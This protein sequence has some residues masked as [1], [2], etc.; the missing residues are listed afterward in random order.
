MCERGERNDPVRHGDDTET[1]DE[2]DH[3]QHTHYPTLKLPSQRHR[4]ETC[5]FRNLSQLQKQ[6]K[7]VRSS[8][9][10]LKLTVNRALS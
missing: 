8:N 1:K 3:G 2:L 5:H 9:A 7:R 6:A 4:I 10:A